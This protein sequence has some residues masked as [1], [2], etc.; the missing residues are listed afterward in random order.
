MSGARGV[1]CE[2]FRQFGVPTLVAAQRLLVV[3]FLHNST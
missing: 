2:L 3:G 1:A